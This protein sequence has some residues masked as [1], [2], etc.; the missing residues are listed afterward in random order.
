M[1]I[2]SGV[3]LGAG[4][5][6]A[7][8]SRMTR[9]ASDLTRA[10][11]QVLVVA[12]DGQWTSKEEG[13]N[14][15]GF[16]SGPSNQNPAAVGPR[17]ITVVDALRVFPRALVLLRR[18]GRTTP[19]IIISTGVWL[20]LAAR[21]VAAL[22]D[23]TYL[24][25]D[26]PGIP[27]LEVA[28]SKPRLWKGKT[29]LYRLVFSR[30]A[31]WA[32]VVT[33]INDTHG[34]ILSDKYGVKPL[35]L[36]DLLPADW[37]ERLIAL[38]EKTSADQVSILYS[39]ALFGSRIERFLR[40]L[41]VLVSEENVTAT[42]IG[43]GPDRERYQRDYKSPAIRFTGYVSREQLLANLSSADVCYS[44]VWHEIGTPYKVLEYMAAGRAV[45]SHDTASLRETIT[46]GFD[47]VL[48]DAVD[49]ALLEALRNLARNQ[50]L[51]RRLGRQARARILDL[52][53]GDRLRGLPEFYRQCCNE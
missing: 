39:G 23:R 44:D 29:R 15:D 12:P 21:V 8:A 11:Y 37:L 53:S 47:G 34:R 5:R 20:P 7:L 31:G 33:T 24:H 10:G 38:P 46:N 41:S 42:I 51:R 25:L 2:L 3:P 48:C 4:G 28:L 16:P 17:S 35:I 49:E 26:V 30:A 32:D 45:V 43:D 9:L 14:L 50:D 18:Q 52:H 13:N 22:R 1:C 40:V 36:P 6:Y 19:V 27:Q